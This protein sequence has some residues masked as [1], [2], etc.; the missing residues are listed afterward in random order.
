[1]DIGGQPRVDVA[2]VHRPGQRPGAGRGALGTLLADPQWLPAVQRRLGRMAMGVC[3][4]PHAHVVLA[5]DVHGVPVG[6]V[7]THRSRRGPV[8]R[9]VMLV[10]GHDLHVGK[11]RP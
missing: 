7:G 4:S 9:W 11:S 1:M 2:A 3:G 8:L 5:E 6:G 10:G